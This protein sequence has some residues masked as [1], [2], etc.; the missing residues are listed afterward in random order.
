MQWTCCW[1]VVSLFKSSNYDR[2][3]THT[4][5]WF[6]IHACSSWASRYLSSRSFVLKAT[7]PPFA[8]R[9]SRLPLLFHRTCQL[10]GGLQGFSPRC[11]SLKAKGGKKKQKKNKKQDTQ[12]WFWKGDKS[13]TFPRICDSNHRIL[14]KKNVPCWEQLKKGN[15]ETLEGTPSCVVFH[16]GVCVKCACFSSM[17]TG[18]QVHGTRGKISVEK[19]L[20]PPSRCPT[21]QQQKQQQQQH[22]RQKATT[23]TTTTTTATTNTTATQHHQ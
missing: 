15:P 6:L 21:K 16:T 13:C 5:T 12:V 22:H 8:R 20:P 10:R 11:Y 1:V 3:Q 14:A 9:T 7:P 18:W 23:T 19:V 4:L 17:F 2:Q